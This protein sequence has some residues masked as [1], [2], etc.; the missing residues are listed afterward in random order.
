[1]ED[2]RPLVPVRRISRG[3]WPHPDSQSPRMLRAATLSEAVRERARALGFD[4]VAIGPA[5]P[6]E[7]GAEFERWLDAGYAGTMEYL[8]RGRAARRDP[9][10]LLPGARSVIAVA[11]GYNQTADADGWAP[12]ARYARGRDYHDVMRPRLEALGEA[13]CEMAG[14]ETRSRACVDTSAV[15]ERDLAARAGLGWIGKNTNLLDQALGSFFFIGIVLTTAELATD[16][17]L[18]DRCGSCT[19]CLRAC[20]TQAF[21]APYVLD[22]RRCISY[23]TIEHRGPVAEE[24]RPA[25]GEWA[26][27]CDICQT[28]CP[29]NRKAPPTSEPAFRPSGPLEP[30]EE[31]LALDDHAF[32]ARFRGSAL[33]RAKRSGLLRSAALV[34][35][36]RRDTAARP[37]LTRRLED[38]DPVVRDAARWALDR[39]GAE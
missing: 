15:L 23:L 19:A 8:A 20:P 36:N 24:L 18:P 21:V 2:R 5:A 17:P 10:T 6:P 28:V 30:L 9:E 12:I 29:W 25:I 34:L 35:G 7:H 1:M 33:R 14:P 27:G 39:I 37:A 16:S 38:P 3:R 4:R 11:L 31:L 32:R 22:S 26:F 13:L